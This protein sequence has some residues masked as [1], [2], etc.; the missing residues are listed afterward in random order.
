MNTPNSIKLAAAAR[1][2]ERLAK[3]AAMGLTEMEYIRQSPAYKRTTQRL[4][5]ELLSHMKAGR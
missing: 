3:A 5:G 2:A 4:A 1:K